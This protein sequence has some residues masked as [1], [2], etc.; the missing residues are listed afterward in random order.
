[1]RMKPILSALVLGLGSSLALAN[2]FVSP[3]EPHGKLILSIKKIPD[4]IYPVQ[5]VA[6][7]GNEIPVRGQAVWMA[8]GEYE[9]K[10]K[11]DGAVNLR[12]LPGPTNLRMTEPGD[13]TLKITV[14]EGMVYYVG[15]EYVDGKWKAV[16]WK[17]EK[18]KA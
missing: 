3:S 14:E 6:V 4:N 11:M 13:N 15:Y 18:A 5:I 2:P 16:V 12:D 1:M 10:I 9:L 7:N 8:P 17:Q